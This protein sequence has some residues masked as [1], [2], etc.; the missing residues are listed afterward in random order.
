MLFEIDMK[1]YMGKPWQRDG[2][3]PQSY[4]CYGLIEAI[5]ADRGII[6][7]EV[8]RPDSLAAMYDKCHDSVGLFK[9]IESIKPF[10]IVTFRT[11]PPKITH[12]GIVLP[13]CKRFIHCVSHAGVIITNLNDEHW[14]TIR[15][16]YYDYAGN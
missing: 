8:N 7:P 1:K 5:Y 14:A 13:D 11:R 6:L 9:P 3:G 15:A 16:G 4:D 12:A 2:R 10:C